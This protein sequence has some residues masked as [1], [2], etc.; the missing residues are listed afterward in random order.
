M[1]ARDTS[2]VKSEPVGLIT[3]E[4]MFDML[5]VRDT[6][7]LAKLPAESRMVTLAFVRVRAMVPASVLPGLMTAPSNVKVLLVPD[8]R[9]RDLL[10][11]SVVSV[12][13]VPVLKVMP[14]GR[15]A[16]AV[17]VPTVTL[18]KLMLGNVVA[19]SVIEVSA[20]I[21]VAL[22]IFRLSLKATSMP[23]MVKSEEIPVIARLKYAVLFNVLPAKAKL[24]LYAVEEGLIEPEPG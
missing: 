17:P 23:D 16:V 8:P 22:A 2:V 7:C 18:S 14:E 24:W 21:P 15:A 1:A 9:V 19:G 10:V 13:A 3:A 12:S 20:F 11:V 5:L 6:F 4:A